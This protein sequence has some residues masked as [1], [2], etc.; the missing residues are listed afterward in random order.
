MS[1]T[2]K[3]I[4]EILSAQV[5]KCAPAVLKYSVTDIWNFGGLKNLKFYKL[6]HH[7]LKLKCYPV[8]HTHTL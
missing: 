3:I 6:S 5:S 7:K 2:E 1:E 4:I 8:K